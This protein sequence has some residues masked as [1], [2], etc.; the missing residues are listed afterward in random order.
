MNNSVA[1]E[2]PEDM[3]ARSKAQWQIICT[4]FFRQLTQPKWIRLSKGALNSTSLHSSQISGATSGK[5]KEPAPK[6]LLVVGLLNLGIAYSNSN[7]VADRA[8]LYDREARQLPADLR[9][10]WQNLIP[11]VQEPSGLVLGPQ[12]IFEAMTGLRDLG[13]ASKRFIPPHSEAQTTIA[14][15]RELRRLFA[16]NKFD[17]MENLPSLSPSCP[18]LEP[19]VMG[20][21]VP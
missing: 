21:S 19:L 1:F 6:F 11:M 7:S 9:H 20:P 10:I 16:Q 2:H 8:V 12:E 15:G 4:P 18:V 17:W 5:T 3:L 14:L 13:I